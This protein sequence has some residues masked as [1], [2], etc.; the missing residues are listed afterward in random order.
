[1]NDNFDALFQ[2]LTH[3]LDR[4][5]ALEPEAAS[6]LPLAVEIEKSGTLVPIRDI[7]QGGVVH[8]RG[9]LPNPDPL[10]VRGVPD[11]L[12]ELVDDMVNGHRINGRVVHTDAGQGLPL[13]NFRYAFV[14]ELTVPAVGSPE[15]APFL[16]TLLIDPEE[17]DVGPFPAESITADDAGAPFQAQVELSLG[18]LGV[19]VSPLSTGA[20]VLTRPRGAQLGL[21]GNPVFRIDAS[22]A[23]PLFTA[24]NSG[25]RISGI[26]IRYRA[27]DGTKVLTVT[28]DHAYVRYLRPDY[29]GDGVMVELTLENPGLTNY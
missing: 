11:A 6:D 17:A 25:H 8:E 13:L 3:L 10:L 1:M 5:S 12:S 4:V 26:A 22:E 28:A 27:P 18:S 14:T 9:A 19:T 15:H 24:F 29:R 16:L 7:E 21:D 23:E 2:D 20:L